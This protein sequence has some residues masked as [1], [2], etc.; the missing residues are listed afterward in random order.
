MFVC[1]WR[2]VTIIHLVLFLVR[3]VSGNICRL[4]IYCVWSM[5]YDISGWMGG[6]LSVY[7]RVKMD[8]ACQF[9]RTLCGNCYFPF[10]AEWKATRYIPLGCGKCCT[11]EKSYLFQ[12]C[13]SKGVSKKG[14][15]YRFMPLGK[16]CESPRRLLPGLH[17]RADQEGDQWKLWSW[18]GWILQFI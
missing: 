15:P 3:W 5:I 4:L 12:A 10:G 2:P 11:G 7:W 1:Y 16:A 14:T 17:R 13:W 9:Y 18:L 6:Y 8:I